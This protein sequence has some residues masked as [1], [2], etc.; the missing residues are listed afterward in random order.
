MGDLDS[1]LIMVPWTHPSP[2][3][4]RH[5]DRLIH[6]CRT[7]NRD[8]PTDRQ[9]YWVC[10]NRRHST[11]MRHFKKQRKQRLAQKTDIERADTKPS[12]GTCLATERHFEWPTSIYLC[13]C[14]QRYHR[15]TDVALVPCGHSRFNRMLLPLFT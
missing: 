15:N 10:N 2:Q 5:L 8:R 4:K 3:L 12:S 6:F 1:H 13:E 7:H 11:A 14:E 9:R